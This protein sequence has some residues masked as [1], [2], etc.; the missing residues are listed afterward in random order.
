[1]RTVIL[2]EDGRLQLVLTPETEHEK[3]A[4]KT[5][6]GRKAD[7]S[8]LAG[9]FYACSGG[10]TRQSHSFGESRA[11]QSLMVVVDTA[12]TARHSSPPIRL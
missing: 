1:M 6:E 9:E 4:L 3:A 8:I 5:I 2:I 11:A 12:P 7:V 10:W